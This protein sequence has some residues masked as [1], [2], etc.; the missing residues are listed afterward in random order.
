MAAG[1][2]A[3]TLGTVGSAFASSCATQAELQAFQTRVLQTELMMAALACNESDRYNAFIR[4]FTPELMSGGQLVK[5]YFSRVYGKSGT[6]RM[7]SAITTYAN[8][9]SK[10]RMAIG[11]AAFCGRAGE[12]FGSVLQM[13]NAQFVKYASERPNAGRH[14]LIACGAAPSSSPVHTASADKPARSHPA[15]P[16]KVKVASKAKPAND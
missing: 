12:I 13:P 7:N 6:T 5:S 14:G 4:R 8:D 1:V 3:A 16:A 15:K 9:S 10:D 2:F 11:D